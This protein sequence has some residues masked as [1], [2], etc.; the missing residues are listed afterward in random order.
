MQFSCLQK[1][2]YLIRSHERIRR[3]VFNSPNDSFCWTQP[4][5]YHYVKCYSR[6]GWRMNRQ[7]KLSLRVLRW[8]LYSSVEPL[9]Q[10]KQRCFAFCFSNERNCPVD[11][12]S[13]FIG[14]SS[15]TNQSCGNI[16]HLVCE[17]LI[18]DIEAN[19]T[20]FYLAQQTNILTM[21]DY[22]AKQQ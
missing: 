1:K 14:F 3:S 15:Q 10:S 17:K 13:C 9:Y 12:L 7:E 19:N 11:K 22:D 21:I 4:Y 2:Y 6:L 16:F 20:K 5:S 18:C 8:A